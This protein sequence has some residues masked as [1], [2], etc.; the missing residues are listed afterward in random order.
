MS[1]V[2]QRCCVLYKAKNDIVTVADASISVRQNLAALCVTG[3]RGNYDPL[4]YLR[5]QRKADLA[6]TLCLPA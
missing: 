6:F 5:Q 1:H 4:P 3:S 2:R